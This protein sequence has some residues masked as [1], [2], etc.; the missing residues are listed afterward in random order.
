MDNT[1]FNVIPSCKALVNSST[2]Q[3]QPIGEPF[4]VTK[5]SSDCLL[6]FVQNKLQAEPVVTENTDAVNNIWSSDAT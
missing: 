2:I 5:K 6:Q 3:N 4:S 1:E